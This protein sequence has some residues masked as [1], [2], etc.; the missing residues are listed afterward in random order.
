[1]QTTTTPDLLI[2]ALLALNSLYIY[3]IYFATSYEPDQKGEPVEK[4]VLWFLSYYSIRW[5][6][7]F[8]SKPLF[9]CP[10]CMASVHGI[11]FFILFSNY[12]LIYLPF[13]CLILCGL[14]YGLQKYFE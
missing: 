5:F 12:N 3:G 10:P 8:L 11:Y 14:N 7:V 13:Y 1:M 4:N 6:G 9:I 2:F